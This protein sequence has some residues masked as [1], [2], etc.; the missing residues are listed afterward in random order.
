MQ[1]DLAP[2]AEQNGFAPGDSVVNTGSRPRADLRAAL[3]DRQLSN[4]SSPS[5]RH[6]KWLLRKGQGPSHFC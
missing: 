6:T 3:L 4:R 1:V 2:V 5:Q